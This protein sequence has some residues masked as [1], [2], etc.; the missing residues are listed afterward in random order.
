M[1]K[2]KKTAVKKKTSKPAKKAAPKKPAKKKTAKK[3]PK[4]TVKKVVVKKAAKKITKP[5]KASN[6]PAAKKP[7]KKVAKKASDKTKKS[8]GVINTAAMTQTSM[9]DDIASEFDDESELD[10]IVGLEDDA[11]T[12]AVPLEDEDVE[13]DTGLAFENLEDEESSDDMEEDMEE[14]MATDATKAEEDD[15]EGYF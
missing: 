5:S 15:D 14:D 8:A 3:M 11:L 7:A 12:N 1:A 6:K 13:E 2:K 4:K 10:A 9:I